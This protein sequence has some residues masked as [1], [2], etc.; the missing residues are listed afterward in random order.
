ME[1]KTGDEF[2]IEGTL[3]Q[4]VSNADYNYLINVTLLDEEVFFEHNSNT[5][6]DN[7]FDAIVSSLE[8]ILLDDNFQSLLSQFYQ[9]NCG[10]Y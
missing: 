1:H 6:E 8:D 7:E 4:S 9:N 3:T 2:D 5:A 10:Q